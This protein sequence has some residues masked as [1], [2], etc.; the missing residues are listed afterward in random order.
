[1]LPKA[2]H[3]KYAANANAL[4]VKKN[5]CSQANVYYCNNQ[6]ESIIPVKS[7]SPNSWG[8]YDMFGNGLLMKVPKRRLPKAVVGNLSVRNLL[9]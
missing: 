7:L 4:S 2:I 8:L 1:M 9:V 6:S 5:I 3:R